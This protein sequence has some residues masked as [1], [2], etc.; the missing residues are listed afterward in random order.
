MVR[1]AT[2]RAIRDNR[3]S[4]RATRAKVEVRPVGSDGR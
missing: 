1:E 3:A 4:S 2:G